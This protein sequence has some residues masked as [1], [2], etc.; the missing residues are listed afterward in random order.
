MHTCIPIAPF[1]FA[2]VYCIRIAYHSIPIRIAC[3]CASHHSHCSFQTMA[4]PHPRAILLCT[5]PPF[6]LAP[7]CFSTSD[8]S[9]FSPTPAGQ[10]DPEILGSPYLTDT[11][12]THRSVPWRSLSPRATILLAWRLQF[13]TPQPIDPH[14]PPLIFITICQYWQGSLAIAVVYAVVWWSFPPDDPTPLESKTG[15]WRNSISNFFW[16]SPEKPGKHRKL[17]T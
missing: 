12:Q 4:L 8:F 10:P 11:F 1:S 3:V 15:Q 5:T 9:T 13:T 2:F 16:N 17:H 7:I 6:A 14:M